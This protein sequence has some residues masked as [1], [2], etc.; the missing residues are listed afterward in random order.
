LKLSEK[1]H[2]NYQR[3]RKILKLGIIYTFDDVCIVSRKPTKTNHVNGKLHCEDGP[4]IEYADGFAIYMLNGVRMKKEHVMTPWNEIDVKKMILKEKNAEVRREL[5]R[6]V[7]MERFIESTD[8][9]VV[10][11]KGDYELLMVDIGLGKDNKKPYLKMKNPSIGVY[12]VEG[13]DPSCK[14]VDDALEF[15]NKTKETPDKLS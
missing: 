9:E 3:W 4:A 11:T 12:H 1:D 2:D 14:T 10:D 8:S 13:V 15:R 7:G 5:V 6:K